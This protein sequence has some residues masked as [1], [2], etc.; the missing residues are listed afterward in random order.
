[1][2]EALLRHHLGRTSISIEVQSAG[3]LG[4]NGAPATPHTLEALAELGVELGAHVSRKITRQQVDEAAL[5]IAM[6]RTHAWAVAAHDPEA[7]ARTFLLDELVRLGT[8]VGPRGG[9]MLDAWLA[10]LDALRPPDRLGRA[11]EEVV[12]PAGEAI[13]VYRATAAR[14]DRSVRRLMPLLASSRLPA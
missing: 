4:W 14:L 6:T 12:D 10:E 3:T 13:D 2:A 5:I 9:E 1:M 8:Q 11:S 7:A